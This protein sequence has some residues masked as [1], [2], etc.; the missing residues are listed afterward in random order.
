V[1]YIYDIGK[2][3]ITA[4]EYAEFLNAVAHTDTYGLY[5]TSMWSNIWGC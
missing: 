5:N 4:G 3:E 1:S 2:F